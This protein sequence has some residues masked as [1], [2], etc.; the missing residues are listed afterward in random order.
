MFGSENTH[1]T[2]FNRVAR[3][4]GIKT[5]L[6]RLSD[7]ELENYMGYA[8][9]R[10]ERGVQDLEALGIESA[11][12]FAVSEDLGEVAMAQVIQLHPNQ[13]TLFPNPPAA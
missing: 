4:N 1:T 8:H 12:R 5:H 13:G 3:I 6:E 10:I 11:L 7:E 2:P 9:E